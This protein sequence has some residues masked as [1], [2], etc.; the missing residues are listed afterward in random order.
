M[1]CSGLSGSDAGNGASISELKYIVTPSAASGVSR[2]I[3]APDL[4]SSGT[5]Q[6]FGSPA[7]S[8]IVQWISSPRLTAILATNNVSL[9]QFPGTIVCK[10]AAMLDR[11]SLPGTYFTQPPKVFISPPVGK[12]ALQNAL[13]GSA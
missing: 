11:S 10:N 5:V 2:M 9:Q 8:K 3:G 4:P 6:L 13:A 1:I 7:L 12:I